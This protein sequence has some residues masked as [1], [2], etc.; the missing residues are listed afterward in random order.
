VQKSIY[1]N[2]LKVYHEPHL[3]EK[4]WDIVNGK[5][6][7]LFKMGNSNAKGL[8]WVTLQC[9]EFLEWLKATSRHVN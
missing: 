5:L 9:D 8:E 3:P 7:K 6:L 1:Q 4:P 2:Y